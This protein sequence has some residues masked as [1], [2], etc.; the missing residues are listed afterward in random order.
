MAAYEAKIKILEKLLAVKDEKI[1]MLEDH[2]KKL[3]NLFDKVP[4]LLQ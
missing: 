3:N 2:I 4:K 1:V